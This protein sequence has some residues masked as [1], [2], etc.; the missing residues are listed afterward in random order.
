MLIRTEQ[1]ASHTVSPQQFM[2]AK[3]LQMTAEELT[4]YLNRELEE[5]PVL[6]IP[7]TI[8]GE[9]ELMKQKFEWLASFENGNQRYDSNDDIDDYGGVAGIRGKCDNLYDHL[10]AQ[11]EILS[12][13]HKIKALE[14]YIIYSL[15]KSGRLTESVQ[16]LAYQAGTD[17]ALVRT[18]L[19]EIQKLE[20]AGIGARNLSECL[21]LQLR[22]AGGDPVCEAIIMNHL[23]D[24]GK[25]RFI[26][27]AKE[28]GVPENTVRLAYE[29]IKCFDP[30]PGNSFD[31]EDQPCYILPELEVIL[32]NDS[33]EVMPIGS[34]SPEIHISAAYRSLIRYSQDEAIL[35]Y[36]HTYI[37]RAKKPNLLY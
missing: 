27:I 12:T 4:E 10:L 20:P 31:G 13:S 14:K 35:K 3:L 33:F 22:R 7:D 25:K 16:D 23:E 37:T 6:E 11:L 30:K 28:L 1:K 26:K 8:S 36:L 5:N 32:S 29:K 2:N 18:A 19:A 17:V 9:L 15:D 21:L 24:L 34:F